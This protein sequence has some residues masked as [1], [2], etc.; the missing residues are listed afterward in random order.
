M[1]TLR[2]FWLKLWRRR[3]LQRDLQ[4]ELAFHRDMAR[5]QSNPIG[6]GN[7]ASIEESARD[8]WRFNL[9]EDLWRDLV[10]ACRSFRRTP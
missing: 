9:L 6:L 10:Y 8:L 2:G 5:D 3:G 4:E 1:A 7:A